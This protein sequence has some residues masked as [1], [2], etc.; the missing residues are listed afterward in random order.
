MSVYLKIK[1]SWTGTT[2]F[3]LFLVALLPI[4]QLQSRYEKGLEHQ[5]IYRNGITIFC[6]VFSLID[7]KIKTI[8]I[9]GE[10]IHEAQNRLHFWSGE[11]IHCIFGVATV[12]EL[13]FNI[14]TKLIWFTKFKV[15]K[16]RRVGFSW[17]LNFWNPRRIL[18]RIGIQTKNRFFWRITFFWIYLGCLVAPTG[19][20]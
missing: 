5:Q 17:K 11:G 16:N 14:I 10:G 8:C 1:T 6:W 2:C 4:Q 3:F 12:F 19:N 7:I 18:H 15:P 9:C 20:I 13:Y